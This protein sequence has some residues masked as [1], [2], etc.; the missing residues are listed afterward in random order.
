M[1]SYGGKSQIKI[2]HIHSLK[3]KL[4]ISNK[5]ALTRTEVKIESNQGGDISE[6]G[7][8]SLLPLICIQC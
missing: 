4:T 8:T 5:L 3:M 1:I 2:R 7:F 6:L